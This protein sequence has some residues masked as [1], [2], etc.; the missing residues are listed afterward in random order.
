MHKL[1][2][3][4]IVIYIIKLVNKVK[5]TIIIKDKLKKKVNKM[6]YNGI[7]YKVISRIKWI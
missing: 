1:M 4:T 2:N 6:K 5:I 3:K 7:L